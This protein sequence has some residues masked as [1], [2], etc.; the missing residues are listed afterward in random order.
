MI[1]LNSVEVNKL[2]RNII[3]LAKGPGVARGKKL[4]FFFK[5]YFLKMLGKKFRIFIA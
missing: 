5:I 3:E 2:I 4:E 1:I